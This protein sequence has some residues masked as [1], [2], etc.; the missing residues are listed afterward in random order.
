MQNCKSTEADYSTAGID[1]AGIRLGKKRHLS[2]PEAGGECALTAIA[3][4]FRNF[5][6]T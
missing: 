5:N 4:L 6:N 3:L 2:L 1:I